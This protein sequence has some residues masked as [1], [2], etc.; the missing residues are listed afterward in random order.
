MKKYFQD[1]L[2]HYLIGSLPEIESELSNGTS[3]EALLASPRVARLRTGYFLDLPPMAHVQRVVWACDAVNP[4]TLLVV[5]DKRGQYVWP[6]LQKFLHTH[7]TICPMGEATV[8]HA[9]QEGGFKRLHCIDFETLDELDAESFEASL[10]V[11][12][13]ESQ[14]EPELWVKEVCE[15]TSKLVM[16]ITPRYQ[17]N[18]FYHLH[19]FDFERLRKMF[20]AAQF[21]NVI[22]EPIG[23]HVLSLARR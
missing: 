12:F 17:T 11:N 7:I 10:M 19:H 15:S 13:L 23:N 2:K 14:P 9:M 4:E 5:G 22:C 6:L 1:F 16:A 8:Y 21:L 18:N 3:L 20:A